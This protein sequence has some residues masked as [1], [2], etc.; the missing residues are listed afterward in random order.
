M[1]EN[2]KI[3]VVEDDRQE[4][5]TISLLLNQQGIS[6]VL[7]SSVKEAMDAISRDAFDFVLSDLHIDTR[8]GFEKPD[9]LLVIRA[10][11]EQQPNVTIVAMSSDPR[12]EIWNEA[13]SAG[14]HHFIRKPLSKADEIVI[15]FGL[16]RERKLLV[17]KSKKAATRKPEGRWKKYADGYPHGIVIGERDMRRAR[18]VAK[19]RSASCIVIGETGTGKEEIAKLIHRL[20]SEEEG[21]I[22]YVA[23]NCAT[24]TGTLAESLLFG[25]RK[26]AFTGAEQSTI[27]FIGEADGGILFL[28][29]IQTLDIPTQQKLLRVLNDGTYNRVGESKAYR[30]QFQLIAASTRDLDTEVD[31]GRFLID[32]R[33]RMIGLDMHLP[34]LRERSEDIPAL[35][36]LYLSKKGIEI[37]DREFDTLVAKLKTFYW[38]G[39]IRQLFKALESWILLCEFDELPLTVENFPVSRGMLKADS[40]ITKEPAPT[41]Q[42][43]KHG[44]LKAL[45]EDCDF[46]KTVSEFEHAILDAA[47]KRHRSIGECCKALKL[48][49]STLDAKRRKYGFI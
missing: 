48:P 2:R 19:K 44:F 43:E 20:R 4:I 45:H 10:A 46:E 24:I 34:P 28:D 37:S 21:T 38:S 9:G 31:E 41:L 49:R 32:I 23:V 14:A 29:E 35:T 25:H 1:F 3:L 26:G 42:K 27:G 5:E 47:L 36:A 18:G 11:A 16:A 6:F 15:A 8:A 7:A 33:T 13:L 17:G 40:S 22:P 12:T 39:N 30:S